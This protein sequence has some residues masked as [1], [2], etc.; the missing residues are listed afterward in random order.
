[1]IPQVNV[2]IDGIQSETPLPLNHYEACNW[3]LD[4]A[5]QCPIP[6]GEETTWILDVPIDMTT[7]LV[8]AK[9]E[10]SL[11]ANDGKSQFCFVLL[12]KIV[13]FKE[14]N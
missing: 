2:T 13:A 5:L 3:L 1:M 8:S 6:K 14:I 4:D 12:S 7:P 9:L 10:V 11:F